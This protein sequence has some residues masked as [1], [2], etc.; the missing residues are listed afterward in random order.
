MAILPSKDARPLGQLFEYSVDHY[1][2]NTA[3]ECDDISL[4]Y[5]ELEI[6]ANQFAH[7]LISQKIN[8][9]AKVGIL[10]ERSLDSY[11]AI[12]AVL[13]TGATYIPIEVEYPDERIN[14]IFTD[15]PF[16]S[17]ITTSSQLT[18]SNI[19]FPNTIVINQLT[20]L[21][22]QLPSTR[23][24]TPKI[25]SDNVCYVIYTSG[26]TGKPKGVEIMHRSASHY[27]SHASA[28]YEMSH[29]DKVYQGFSL[30]FDASIEE[31]WMAFANGATLV[32]GTSKEL[33]SGVGLVDFLREKNVNVLSTVPTLLSTLEEN[34][35]SSLRLL[36]LGGEIC[37]PSLIKRYSN[38]NLRILNT[39]GPT[40]TTVIA[41]YAECHPDK[42]ITIGKPL[43]GYE[44][45]IMDEHLNPVTDGQAGEL[46]IGGMGLARGYV[47]RPE[48]TA[49]KFVD[50]PQ[51]SGH[52][53]YRTG[54]LATFNPE[55][56]CLFLGRV[57]D[58]VKIR[59]F[60]VELN[61]IE[62]VMMMHEAI[63]SAV[64]SLHD[65]QT[66][67]VLV[68]WLIVD[69]TH[70]FDL[71]DFKNHLRE[72]LPHY[73][74][75]ALFKQVDSFPLLASGK[76]NRKAFS[77]PEDVVQVMDYIPPETSMEKDIAHVFADVLQASL[78]SVTADF[79][80]DLGGHSLLA[81][82]VISSLRKHEAFK[83][84]SILDLYSNPSIRQLAEKFTIKSKEPNQEETIRKK[85]KVSTLG[86]I[87]CGIGQFFGCLFMY[88]LQ[89]W[90]LLLIV[91]C[92]QSIILQNNWL[93]IQSIS[94]VLGFIVALPVA[95]T[96]TTICL[97]WL[98]L[99][100][101]KPGKYKLWG[102][103]YF[104]WWLVDRLH[105]FVSPQA[106]FVGTP[107]I[108]IY[109]RLMGAK[110]GSQCYIGTSSIAIFDTL[111]IGD[112]TSIGYE[113]NLLGYTVE[114]GWLKI[115][116][117]T[118]GQD[119]F[120]GS[121]SAVSID[122][123]IE[124]GSILDHMTMLPSHTTA[125]ENAFYC[126]SPARKTTLPNEH[127]AN[128]TNEK[129]R[130]SSTRKTFTYGALHYICLVLAETLHFCA[131]LPSLLFISY[132]YLKTE[133]FTSIFLTAPFGALLSMSLY[134]LCIVFY[135][136]LLLNKIEQ[137]TYAIHSSF[138]LR[139]WTLIKLLDTDQVQVLADS[140]YFPPLLR[141]LGAKLGRRVEMGETPHILPNLVQIDDEAFTASSVGLAW[142]NVFQGKIQMAPV[143]IGKKGFSGNV[144]ILPSGCNLGDESLLGCLTVPPNN[145]QAAKDNTAWLGSPAIFLPK[146]ELF[147]GF[148]DQETI[149]PPPKLYFSRLAIELIRITLPTTYTLIGAFSLISVLVYLLSH[150]SLLMTFAL[151][152]LAESGII[153]VLVA[154]LV[155]L[156]WSLQGRLKPTVKPL[157]DIF[158][159]KI[160]LIEFS[161]AYFICP[162]LTD[163]ILKTPFMPILLRCLGARI[164]KKVFV[165]TE[166]FAE[167]DLISIGNNVNINADTLIDTHLYEDRIFKLSTIDIHE[168][169][170]IGASSIV[171]YD[172]VMEKDSTL[173]NL[174]LLMKGERL[175]ANTRWEGIPAQS[176]PE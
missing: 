40:E 73:M 7:Y 41:T 10:L 115:G 89:S 158:I 127:I 130:N 14:Y 123:V 4:T 143:K 50:H 34:Q 11:I 69:S 23:P 49:E 148:S 173:G 6:R 142:P 62:A 131:Y 159:R 79:F 9:Q 126:G 112:N 1:P 76:V 157:W 124:N 77:L 71:Q 138:Y 47:N 53:L 88:A 153:L 32:V 164:G 139:Q 30:A 56:D 149:N 140:L 12:L 87:T 92:N 169:C 101:V 64:V 59:G 38:P 35:L 42:P 54:D 97:K 102:W 31:L 27:V 167:F 26:S 114:D 37:L 110:I 100:R 83:G 176:K 19:R 58:Q 52:R 5:Q 125:S 65:D 55:G 46:C 24:D 163:V 21:L 13:K 122:T 48:L 155:L 3:I 151:L 18:R 84:I 68:A 90:Q 133:S 8:E 135:K 144:S 86:Y 57:D 166:G 116:E 60:R 106:K 108:S 147:E 113:V 160:D 109:Y 2:E 150:S 128:L 103:F 29:Q 20:D 170:N 45:L 117:I 63:N 43:P 152:P 129:M 99:G 85:H 82:K 154:S 132:V 141:F 80:Y 119:C 28:L 33:R 17:V 171:L 134:Y 66:S 36:I 91:L 16:D 111:T 95:L 105:N 96:L 78:I 44:L 172:T 104:R 81:A 146:R 70:P 174:S 165:G 93:S 107:I 39:Y 175:P 168:G 75:P 118:I 25:N 51:K 94:I 74:I 120:I 98:I 137:G 136:K 22:P 162:N 61:E 161:Y 121:R 15:M 67:P 72:Q 156:K 145:N